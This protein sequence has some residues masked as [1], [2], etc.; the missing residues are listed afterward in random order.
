MEGRGSDAGFLEN[1]TEEQEKEHLDIFISSCTQTVL[2]SS[3]TMLVL[4]PRS[5]RRTCGRG[6]SGASAAVLFLKVVDF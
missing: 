2:V 4:K 1:E 3:N 6:D 5:C